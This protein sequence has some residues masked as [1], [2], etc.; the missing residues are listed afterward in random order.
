MSVLALTGSSVEELETKLLEAKAKIIE[1][2]GGKL[3]P[4]KTEALEKEI[5][6]QVER[7]RRDGPAKM[8]M[9]TIIDELQDLDKRSKVLP[10]AVLGLAVNADST[11]HAFV[12]GGIC[13]DI[14]TARQLLDDA[15]KRLRDHMD[16]ECHDEK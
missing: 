2:A 12:L 8:S 5:A 14:V 7:L 3:T 1:A 4:E 9:R 15:R 10:D 11:Q 16:C 6:R 13:A